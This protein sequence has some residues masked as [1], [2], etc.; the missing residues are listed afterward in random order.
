MKRIAALILAAAL[1]LS[2]LAGCAD[3]SAQTQSGAGTPSQGTADAS[4]AQETTL[5]LL[6]WHPENYFDDILPGFTEENPG[7]TVDVQ[8]VPPVTQYVDKF[9]VLSSSNQ[10]PD[11]FYTAAENKQEI[12]ERKLAED[13]SDL[14]IF[15]RID[16]K[17]ASMWGSGGEIYGFASD[18]WIGGIFYN[19]DLF[20]QAGVTGE[21]RTW[22]EFLDIVKK[23]EESGIT[24]YVDPQDEVINLPIMLYMDS[25]I[26]KDRDADVKIN[27]GTATFADF[28]TAPYETW[29]ND[30]VAT[31]LYDKVS[32]G[33][34][35][36]QVV[37]MFTTGQ[38]AMIRGG[39]WSLIQFAEK[40]PDL[41]Y[42]VFPL[43]DQDGNTVL[44]GAVG[45]GLSIS[46]ASQ[47]KEL[48]RTFINYMAK[49]ENIVKWQQKTG[50]T[51]V[52]S[53]IEYELDNVFG[54]YKQDAIDGNF[55]WP[56]CVWNN[57]A[58]IL[59]E[60]YTATQDV[61]SGADT[62]QNLPVRLDEKMAELSE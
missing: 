59:T 49:D 44:M 38:A 61:I 34:S 51:I 31:G 2:L 54:K 52:V 4:K 42:D 8:Y 40:N 10:M 23:L 43:P 56:H 33:L 29:Y 57:S 5:S 20:A 13:I 60:L 1:A 19:K 46:S 24:A 7:V 28:Y 32:I 14:A 55:Y 26:S 37:D 22:Q 27:E 6:S 16:P 53:G 36:D 15:K 11:L 3:T 48:C 58:G 41:N 21:P 18:T 12:I 25:V 35:N 9:M 50:Y 30:M 39:P 47:N 17:V 62:V 45:V